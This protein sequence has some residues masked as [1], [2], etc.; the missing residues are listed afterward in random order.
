[1]NPF[2]APHSSA[3]AGADPLGEIAP[4][5][6]VLDRRS[7]LRIGGLSLTLAPLIAA[8]GGDT[9]GSD[10]PG[11]IGV[12][13]PAPELQD[14]EVNDIVLL[15]TA[16]SLEYTAQEIYAA[17]VATGALTPDQDRLLAAINEDHSEHIDALASL[18]S[19]AGGEPFRCSNPFL[20]QR[21]VEPTLI[22]LDDS[23]DTAGDLMRIA[24]AIETLAAST[25]QMFIGMLTDPE[26][27]AAALQ[28]GADEAR[29]SA[30]VAIVAADGTDALLSPVLFGSELEATAD[31]LP[32]LYAVPSRFSEV[33]ANE[34]VLNAPDPDG[35]LFAVTVQT[36]AENSYAYEYMQC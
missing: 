33:S 8:C 21:V 4:T 29:H 20:V 28:I 12:A 32:V 7:L 24:F 6:A 13:D 5:T 26:L 2:T 15:R 31:G 27:R 36:P 10:G 11:R 17:A 30:A 18:I 3:P 1:M 25:Y 14:G 35:G 16:M 22:A 23:A 19:T 34:L 9:L